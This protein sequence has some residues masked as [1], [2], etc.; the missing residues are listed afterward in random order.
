MYVASVWRSE[1]TW[2]N[3][4]CHSV[5]WVPGLN[6]DTLKKE[7]KKYLGLTKFSRLVL[8]SLCNLNSEALASRVLDS[9]LHYQTWLSEFQAADFHS[10]L[11]CSLH[12]FRLF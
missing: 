11:C 1:E 5:I 12:H 10:R 7:V 3:S 2:H 6:S 9:E 8:V 4:A